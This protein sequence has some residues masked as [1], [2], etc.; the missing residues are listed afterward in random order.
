[1][2]PQTSRTS[3]TLWL[4][5]SCIC[6]PSSGKGSSGDQAESD[7]PEQEEHDEHPEDREKEGS[8]PTTATNLLRSITSGISEER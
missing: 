2:S 7:S 1:M 3:L 8:N 5:S 4:H 6:T